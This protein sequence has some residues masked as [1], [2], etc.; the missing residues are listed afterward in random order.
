MP[1]VLDGFVYCPGSITLK[2][3]RGLKTE[4]FAKE[5]ELNFLSL[6]RVLHGILPN[7]KASKKA[8]LVFFSTVAVKVG[9]PFHTSIS[10]AKGAIEG[11][12]R[13]LAAEYAPSLR[14][15]VIAPS[16]TDTPLAEKL[17]SNQSKRGM[18][19][20]RHPLRR[21]GEAIDIAHLVEYLL[22]DKSSWM[23]GQTLGIDG[24]LSSLN[25]N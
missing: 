10:A 17:I 2:P 20:E 6:I 3:F 19:E 16:L 8:S 25:L 24:G 7:L 15:N 21:I 12:A 1:E 23:T 22:S 11:F 14:V 5:L 9:M 18:I 13:S 4:D